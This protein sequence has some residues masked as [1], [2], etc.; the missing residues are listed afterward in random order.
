MKK[1]FLVFILGLVTTL[2][3]CSSGENDVV[4]EE[5]LPRFDYVNVFESQEKDS[6]NPGTNIGGVQISVQ[7]KNAAAT[8]YAVIVEE[9]SKVPTEEQIKEGVAYDG[10]TPIYSKSSTRRIL[11]FVTSGLENGTVYDFYSVIEEEEEFSKIYST[12]F[13]TYSLNALQERGSGTQS[14]P[15][16]VYTVE[17]LENVAQ[18]TSDRPDALSSYYKQMADIDVST[19]YNRENGES[20]TPIATYGTEIKKFAGDYDGNGYVIDKLYINDSKESVGL[21]GVVDGG[22]VRNVTLTNV[23]I[24]NTNQ[25]RTAA[26]VGYSKGNIYNCHVIGGTINTPGASIPRVGGI[27][28]EINNTTVLNAVSVVDV[29][30]TADGQDVGGIVGII[31]VAD[32]YEIPVSI[33]NAYSTAT[34]KSTGTKGYVGGIVGQAKGYI[35][36]TNVYFNGIVEGNTSASCIGGMIGGFSARETGGTAS[37]TNCF[38][39]GSKIT[40]KTGGFIIGNASSNSAG[41]KGFIADNVFR[42]TDC[43]A[44]LTTNNTPDLI[45]ATEEITN[46]L[47]EDYLKNINFNFSIG[48]FIMTT[49]RPVISELDNGSY[50]NNNV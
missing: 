42:S 34:V 25:Q 8:V 23:D 1:I 12:S 46:I 5:V 39:I 21:F 50:K 44:N 20:F 19:V 18:I 9:G 24:T 47:T 43:V 4:I 22:V 27:V 30:I 48:A 40:G 7:A 32:G 13:N 14:D 16:L 17:E 41:L 6:A 49:G 45:N 3:A 28:G 33:E 29:E 31:Q 36:L 37:L 11:E 2:S 38:V 15:Y 26:L 10:V 35:V